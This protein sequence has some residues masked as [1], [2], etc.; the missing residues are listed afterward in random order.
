MGRQTK[1]VSQW[2]FQCGFSGVLQGLSSHA[3]IER[4]ALSLPTHPFSQGLWEP[5]K[6][7]FLQP[8]VIG[9]RR[10]VKNR[11]RQE[12]MEREKRRDTYA[13]MHRL[14]HRGPIPSKKGEK[15]GKKKKTNKVRRQWQRAPAELLTCLCAAQSHP[16][17]SAAGDLQA[18]TIW[19]GLVH[20]YT[21]V[22]AAPCTNTSSPPNSKSQFGNILRC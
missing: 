3:A 5:H 20:L 6:S 15:K 13:Q 7:S 11:G 19:E 1:Q 2:P 14:D 22:S 10:W 16:S 8:N 17:S 12:Q 4:S 18:Q 21:G 9:T